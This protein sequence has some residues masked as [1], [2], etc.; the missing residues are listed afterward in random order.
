MKKRIVSLLL[1]VVM[2]ASVIAGCTPT[3]NTT[4]TGSGENPPATDASGSQTSDS[5][6]GP[7]SQSTIKLDVG[8]NALTIASTTEMSGDFAPGYW[9]NNATDNAIA[10]FLEENATIEL[11][12]E[13]EYVENKTVLAAPIE[14]K[15][16]ENGSKIFTMKIKEGLKFSDGSPITA[17]D[18]VARVLFFSS[19][20]LGE[21]EAAPTYGS[22][23]LGYLD[24]NN[25]KTKEF[26]GVRLI[27]DMTFS[28][29]IDP[30]YVPSYFEASFA[31][32]AP[33]KLDFWCDNPA[34]GKVEIKDDG[35]GAYFSDNFTKENFAESI[36]KAK[37]NP[38]RVTSGPYK[39]K[40]YD[41]QNKYM[42]LEKDPNYLGDYQGT[43]PSID[44][45]VFK[46]VN[47]KVAVDELRTG[48]V[49]L[50]EGLTSGTEINAGFDLIDAEPD[51]FGVVE[52]PRA[53]Y[54]KL[55]FICDILPTKDVEVRQAIAHLLDRDKFTQSFTGGYGRVVH[56]PYGEGQ[57]MFKEAEKDLATKL[58]SYAYDLNK[59]K[60]LLDK[61]GWNLDKDG[62]PYGG[63]GLRHKKDEKGKLVPLSLNWASTENN[64]VTEALVIELMENPDVAAAGMEVK[65]DTMSF[66]ELLNYM[67]RDGS[68]GEKYG[69]P[70]YHMMN[71]AS[72][73][74]ASYVPMYTYSTDPKH[75]DAGQNSN[76]I[77]DKEL[78]K[79]ATSYWKV[80]KEDKAG[81]VK[82]YTD[83][84]VKW[85][86]LLPDLPLYSNIYHDFF[87][88]KLKDY[89]NTAESEP[90]QDILY[91]R[92]EE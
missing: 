70:Y 40:K 54:G 59:A 37:N 78:E 79:L 15:E 71:L 45:I 35:K 42:I 25:G 85:N 77:I 89:K 83:Y 27:D 18:Y 58:D 69:K 52:Y 47:D 84:L 17:K 72:N 76:F 87:N 80:D 6:G 1:P 92:V 3:T 36:N 33:M 61:A 26:K 62:K 24:F 67:Y 64:P 86:Q 7:S 13:N 90:W 63:T 8:P 16:G 41:A 30:E 23:Y 9:Q 53:G 74:P 56:G 12:R 49:D 65:Q 44:T 29:E 4:T 46:Y 48:G 20:L 34:A 81:F 31:G 82:G 57:W 38:D 51:K 43:K 21:L 73:F 68:K 10:S 11:S 14:E 60:E 66:T 22:Y 19:P 55:M 75:L 5:Q 32:V 2:A 88:A 91:S 28:V 50:L 39:V